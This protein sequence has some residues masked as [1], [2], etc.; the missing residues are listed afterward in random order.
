MASSIPPPDSGRTTGASGTTGTGAIA[1]GPN[2]APQALLDNLYNLNINTIFLRSPTNP[3]EMTYDTVFGYVN[4]VHDAVTDAGGNKDLRA[5]LGD[6]ELALGNVKYYAEKYNQGTSTQSDITQLLDNYNDAVNAARTLNGE[7]PATPPAD[8]TLSNP[9][10]LFFLPRIE[11][12]KTSILSDVGDILGFTQ[13]MQKW[14]E[15]GGHNIWDYI[16]GLGWV[17]TQDWETAIKNKGN[18][19]V[20]NLNKLESLMNQLPYPVFKDS[21]KYYLKPDSPDYNK[22]CGEAFAQLTR[23]INA[24][25]KLATDNP[26]DVT[27]EQWA[28]AA[29]NFIGYDDSDLNVYHT[30]LKEFNYKDDAWD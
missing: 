12:L 21:F 13:A 3:N 9:R 16:G 11:A 22:P 30:V 19:A 4:D 15:D 27:A 29:N 6:V 1:T 14:N 8:E 24:L 23:P 2:T 28:A 26:S 10:L 17:P 25:V 20:S 5:T 18:E 7:D